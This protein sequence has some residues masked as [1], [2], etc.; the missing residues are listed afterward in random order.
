MKPNEIADGSFTKIGWAL[1]PGCVGTADRVSRRWP[2]KVLKALDTGLTAGITMVMT[3]VWCATPFAQTAA[4]A[5]DQQAA[6]FADR[7]QASLLALE[8]G[9]RDAPRDHWDPL[10]VVDEIGIEPEDLF[11]WVKARVA[12][13][14]YAGALR[15]AEGVLMDR[16]GNSLD[17]SLLLARLLAEAGHTARLAHAVLPDDVVDKLWAELAAARA[18]ATSEP[19]AEE[20]PETASL[21]EAADLYG[22]DPATVGAVIDVSNSDASRLLVDLVPEVERS[23]AALAGLVG[24]AGETAAA[25]AVAAARAAFADHWWVEYEEDGNWVEMDL[26]AYDAGAGPPVPAVDRFDPEA[27][28]DG[29]EQTVTIR[30]IAEQLKGGVLGERTVL[31]QAIRP[32]DLLGTTLGFRHFPMAWPQDW[33]RMTPD[34]VQIKLRA[35]LATQV[36][37]M[38]VL[39]LGDEVL[40]TVAV[41]DTGDLNPDPHPVNPFRQ[42]ATAMIGMVSKATDVLATGGDPDRVL[43]AD[44]ELDV[45]RPPREEG[46][47]VAERVEFTITRPGSAPI[48]ASRD[49]FDLIG[50]DARARGDVSGFTMSGQKALDRSMAMLEESEIQ[51]LAS[52][53]HP[54]FLI[55]LGAVSALGNRPVLD[56]LSRDPFGR[57]PSN[58]MELFSKLSG[59]PFA[60]YAMS[61]PRDALNPFADWV[62][63]DR[64]TIV[65]QHTRL[66]RAGGGDFLAGISLDIVENGVG[67]DPFAADLAF[68][69]RMSQGVAD[70][71]AEAVAA[72]PTGS[73]EP[74]TAFGFAATEPAGAGWIA[75]RPGDQQLLAKLAWP[76]DARAR[77]AR[78]LES[79]QVLV[80]PAMPSPEQARGGWW[81]VDP[82][83]GQTLGMSASGHGQAMVEYALIIIIETMMAAAQCALEASLS[84]AL[85][86]A[87]A[88]RAAGAGFGDATKAGAKA[89]ATQA[90]RDLGNTAQ[91]NRCMALGMF[92][93]FK[94]LL[95]GFALHAAR[96]SGDKG[97]DGSKRANS[98]EQNAV[99]SA[100]GGATGRPGTPTLP[101]L[102]PA[103]GARGA[104]TLPGVAPQAGGPRGAPTLPGVGPEAGGPRGTPG[105][106][107][108]TAP[109]QEAPGKAPGPRS[110]FD[111]FKDAQQR[112]IEAQDKLVNHRPVDTPEG[113]AETSKLWKDLDT[114]NRDRIK[115]WDQMPVGQRPL[116]IPP[117]P[118]PPAGTG[119]S[120]GGSGGGSP[121]GEFTGYKTGQGPVAPS[122]AGAYAPT[123]AAPVAPGAGSPQG[124]FTGYKTGQGP[125]APSD[126][127]AYAPTQA[128]PA[129]GAPDSLPPPS[130]DSLLDGLARQQPNPANARLP[131][132]NSSPPSIDSLLDGSKWAG[133]RMG[134]PGLGNAPT[135]PAGFSPLPPPA[136]NGAPP[137]LPLTQAEASRASG[138]A[139][140]MD[141]LEPLAGQ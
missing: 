82:L 12:F 127:G 128:A 43:S 25:E 58:Y 55:H 65:M 112:A 87:V 66:R 31:E 75:L 70:T 97:Y 83:T 124:E 110:P 2:R 3:F 76:A 57:L 115:A 92:A 38:P 131:P 117:V 120:T 91:R 85:D 34:D 81:R 42:M 21:L 137:P 7:V 94:S 89:G 54:D 136:G 106:G 101:G 60:L 102:G 138:L 134:R 35:A 68:G 96:T 19:A 72:Q 46:E 17:Q 39:T 18:P 11:S 40:G 56:E 126:A 28:P 24:S 47:L 122:D 64:P 104:P 71:F 22:L 86:R 69:L 132:P 130:V 53:L 78:E 100:R 93:G 23:V 107:P 6:I 36:E 74:N 105:A 135:Q 62:H 20:V 16:V 45:P 50:P 98:W 4:D 49:V 67:V 77:M 113:Q 123:E 37:W 63:V 139:G 88:A 41:K 27:L 90:K 80:L 119:V 10:Y 99:N 44:P 108:K 111:Q 125:V 30:V 61:G 114:A 14:P 133:S 26:L 1:L 141:A 52:K 13:V 29:I 121:A 73:V 103:G 129:V 140:L 118:G 5:Q 84:K 79:G 33:P 51:I 109:G 15:G 95:L 59:I 9:D 116:S 48:V 8:D 32:R